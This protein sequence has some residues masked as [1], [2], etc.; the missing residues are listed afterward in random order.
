M[1]RADSSALARS[2]LTVLSAHL[3]A[4]LKSSSFGS[5]IQPS[6]VSAQSGIQPPG[7]LNDSLTIVEDQ[8]GKKYRGYPIEELAES[9]SF[10]EVA[11]LLMYGNLPSESQLADWE[12]A[13][14]QNSAVLQ[15]ILNIIQVMP[16]DAHP[17]GVFIS[18]MSAFSIFHPNANHA[19]RGQDLYQSKQVRDKQIAC[20]LGKAPTIAANRKLEQKFDIK[21]FPT[22]FIVKDGG[23]KVQEWMRNL[24]KR[25]PKS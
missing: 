18:A 3:K 24:W 7:D 11:Y 12:F 16:H 19:L 14:S 13:I 20:V 6:C 9:S 5:V 21:D 2:R 1:E 15:G 23:K 10:L 25:H 4:C 8:T 17:M 22:L